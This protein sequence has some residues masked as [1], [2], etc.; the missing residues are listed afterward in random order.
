MVPF[1]HCYQL[2]RLE[3]GRRREEMLAADLAAGQL[4]AGTTKL[5]C[6]LWGA[7]RRV[8]RAG[9]LWRRLAGFDDR[10]NVSGKTV[11]FAREAQVE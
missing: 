6:E 10:A 8:A 11:A 3:R 2:A 7:V 9:A 5:A 1:N 4:A